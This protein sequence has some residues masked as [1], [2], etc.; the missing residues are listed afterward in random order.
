MF[1]VLFVCF[2]VKAPFYLVIFMHILP[3]LY[4]HVKHQQKY[5]LPSEKEGGGF[6][7]HWL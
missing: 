5:G 1:A 4:A 2:R 7:P 6:I 3:R